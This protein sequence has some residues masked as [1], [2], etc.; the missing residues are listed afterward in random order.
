LP[1]WQSWIFKRGKASSYPFSRPVLQ[2]KGSST[3][4]TKPEKP[5]FL[6]ILS[7]FPIG[8]IGFVYTEEYFF[9]E[10]N[11]GCPKYNFYFPSEG[12]NILFD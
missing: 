3:V 4:Y 12:G 8:P 6:E 7:A 5:V 10:S 1:S 9:L 11:L 2:G